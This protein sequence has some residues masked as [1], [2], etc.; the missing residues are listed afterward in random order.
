LESLRRADAGSYG[1]KAAMLGELA[2]NGI[3]VPDGYAL[4][5]SCFD[6]FL[7][8]NGFTRSPQE[9]AAAAPEIRRELERF[10]LSREASE[11]VDACASELLSR[12]PGESLIVRTSALCEDL[13]A[14]SH[15]GLFASFAGLTSDAA[16]RDAVTACYRALFSDAVMERLVAGEIRAS[17]L[18]AGVIV[19]RYV[20]GTLSGVTFTSDPA[21]GD[22]DTVVLSLATGPCSGITDGSARATT[23]RCDNANGRPT[24]VCGPLDAVDDRTVHRLVDLA[25][26]AEAVGGSPQDIEWTMAGEKLFVVQSR[27]I[28]RFRQS[29]DAAY[30]RVDPPEARWTLTRD[31]CLPPLLAE[32]ATTAQNAEGT[33]AY[34]RGME[35]DAVAFTAVNGYVYQRRREIP[36]QKERLSDYL[37]TI[38]AQFD[39]GEGEYDTHIRP[40]LAALVAEMH[41]RFVG[42]ELSSVDLARY[43]DRAEHY[44]TRAASLHWRATTSE[45][46]LG[47]FFRERVGR[48]YESLSSQDLVDMV[49]STSYMS[50]EREQLY[51]MGSVIDGDPELTELVRCGY[52]R[53]I[54]ARLARLESPATRR[55]VEMIDA[56]SR[57]YGWLHETTPQDGSLCEP[58]R[59][60][61]HECINRIRRYLHVDRDDYRAN[62]D[63][64]AERGRLLRAHGLERCSTDDERRGFELAL[65]AGEKA[66][67]AGDDHAFYICSRKYSYV[68][69]AIRRAAALLAAEGAL[70]DAEDVL[71]LTMPEIKRALRDDDESG[72]DGVAPGVGGTLRTTIRDRRL[73]HER[74]A[75]LLPPQ[76]LGPA[77]EDEGGG[78][79][80]E[81]DQRSAEA[82]PVIRGEGGSRRIGRGRLHIGFPARMPGEDVILLL[83]H[84]H[85]GDLATVLKRVK[86]IVLK[87]GTPACHMGIIARELGIPSLYGVGP[88]ADHLKDGDLVEL[89]GEREELRVM[90]VC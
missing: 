76:H 50:R 16:V 51:D 83:E 38:G 41:E 21:S 28:A 20:A 69:D 74:D 90:G 34:E 56:Y 77:P 25:R 82:P 35:W 52:D 3:D 70:A 44:L 2:A 53:L 23:F 12:R 87:M 1:P 40:E 26:R 62:L 68:C 33:C 8:H 39:R 46:Y 73:R 27:P 31:V 88:Q 30:W 48:Y 65:T 86:G 5:A 22:P 4:A 60:P 61:L 59:V 85:E 14:R 84:G 7:T 47:H 79:P 58:G 6:D 32:L 63:R 37:S 75:A 66:Y 64:I 78:S 89:D 24:A 72:G 43:L 54:A 29:V 49:Y 15:A 45:W 80:S 10:E 17:E 55:L 19:Q 18:K 36:D 81:D 67:L 42:R 13:A 9:L 57:E 71:Y 11:S